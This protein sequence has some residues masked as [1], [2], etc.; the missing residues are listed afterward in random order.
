MMVTTTL[1]GKMGN[2]IFQIAAAIGYAR[3]YGMEY[4]VPEKSL[5]PNV[6]QTY[7]KFP[8]VA[9]FNP[10]VVYQEKRHH[11]IKIPYY[12]DVRLNGYFQSKKYFE[13]CINEVR[14]QFKIQP[15]PYNKVS[16][17]IRRGDYLLHPH[18]FPVL[19]K[20]YYKKGIGHFKEMGFNDFVVFSDDIVWCK[21]NITEDEYGINI[22]YSHGNE[23]DDFYLMSRCT[24]SIIANSSYSLIAGILNK[25]TNQII[26]PFYRRWFGAQNRHLNTID[27]IPKE[28]IQIQF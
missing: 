26:A 14:D 24:N 23:Y 19:P 25:N 1:I 2:Q 8:V 9:D 22:E 13:H 20:S 7:F 18:M 12:A 10:K 15:E 16:I 21:E 4:C 5:D 27:V 6:W 17:H 28:W 3:R 11:Y